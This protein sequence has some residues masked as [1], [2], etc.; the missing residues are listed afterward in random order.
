VTRARTGDAAA[1]AAAA[2]L[3]SAS[4]TDSESGAAA[5]AEKSVYCSDEDEYDSDIIYDSDSDDSDDDAT[6]AAAGSARVPVET[7]APRAEGGGQMEF[8]VMPLAPGAV[9]RLQPTKEFLDS[10]IAY[11][12]VMW[13]EDPDAVRR[14]SSPA[15][16]SAYAPPR[17]PPRT[18]PLT[19]PSPQMLDGWTGNMSNIRWEDLHTVRNLRRL[20]G[21]LILTAIME[22]MEAAHSGPGKANVR[23]VVYPG[24]MPGFGT[25][26]H[27]DG[28]YVRLSL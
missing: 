1:A 13:M 27:C 25:S 20:G 9:S 17:T 18:P 24:D 10:G 2:A 7:K 5:G 26:W 4:E 11:D 21:P 22:A 23:V 12:Q 3:S 15:A 16:R 28:A 8:N 6:A 14:R 19:L